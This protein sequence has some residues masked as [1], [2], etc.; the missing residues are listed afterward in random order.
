MKLMYSTLNGL[1]V[2]L[3]GGLVLSCHQKPEPQTQTAAP[4]A[5]STN[6]FAKEVTAQ[7]TEVHAST[8]IQKIS[9]TGKVNYNPDRVVKFVPLLDGVVSKVNFALGDYVKQGQ[10]LLELRSSELTNLSS[11][12]KTA[13]ATL[14]TAERNLSSVK[15]MYEDKLAT[16]KELVQAESEVDVAKQSIIKAQETLNLYGGSLEKGVLVVRAASNGYIVEKNIVVGQ[17][18]EAGT[19]ALFTISDLKQVW[20]T[21]NIYAGQL[22]QVKE[23]MPVEITTTAYPNT[24]FHGKISRFA[25]VFDPN[26]RVLKAQIFLDNP[27]LLLKPEMFVII[28]VQK[29]GKETTLA[30]P[31]KA[32]VFD[33]DRYFVVQYEDECHLKLVHLTPLF[34]NADSTYFQGGIQVGEKILVKNQL[35]VYNQL[36][37]IKAAN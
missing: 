18:V 19:E 21:A 29:T 15:D 20:V 36:K 32:V 5:D 34:Q 31:T 25:N 26:E 7:T 11:E 3:L 6:C 30:V 23:G 16:E 35:L 1:I 33:D 9:L 37:Q 22:D 12:L 14:R 2:A 10:V 24:V 17:Q 13:Q 8:P 27:G 4:K 28:R